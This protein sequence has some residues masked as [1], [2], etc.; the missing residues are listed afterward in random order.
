MRMKLKEN[1]CK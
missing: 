1:C